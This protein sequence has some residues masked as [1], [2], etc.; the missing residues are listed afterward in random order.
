MFRSGVA[1]RGKL[2][3]TEAVSLA[4]EVTRLRSE[5]QALRGQRLSL[6]P[7]L[8]AALERI[9]ELEQQARKPASMFKPDRPKRS[10]EKKPRRPTCRYRLRG[11]SIA[12]RREVIERP[13]PPP[14]EVIEHQGVKRGW[15]KGERWRRPA[16]DLRGQVL[17][18]GRMGV[19]IASRVGWLR[20]G[21]RLPI[22]AIASYL[23]TVDGLRL[24]TGEIVE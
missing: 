7:E 15:P 1:G 6:Q 16:L 10:A 22:R 5:N 19:R 13:P 14:V 12:R 17:G 20:L 11:E 4:Q 8:A 18:Q 3:H 23:D 21:L 9:A 2:W 24:S